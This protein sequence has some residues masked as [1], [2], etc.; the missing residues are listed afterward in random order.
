MDYDQISLFWVQQF[1]NK[2]SEASQVVEW[3]QNWS[4]LQMQVDY[5]NIH[6]VY[7]THLQP[8]RLWK[9]APTRGA[10]THEA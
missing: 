4:Q 9:L 6:L 3:D 7:Q 5:N 1:V 10:M 8:T 2:T